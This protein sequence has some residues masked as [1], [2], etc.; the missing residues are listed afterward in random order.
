MGGVDE[1]M[2]FIIPTLLGKGILLFLEVNTH[3]DLHLLEA[4][5]Y[6]NGVVQLH[7]RVGD[8]LYLRR[9]APPR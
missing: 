6:G 3:P 2:L 9:T 1:M 8:R 5:A 4:T 7:F